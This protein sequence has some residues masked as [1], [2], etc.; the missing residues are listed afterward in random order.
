MTWIKIG[1]FVVPQYEWML[2]LQARAAM[3]AYR[4]HRQ[5]VLVTHAGDSQFA[6]VRGDG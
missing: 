4:L 6:C 2:A 1:V 5:R 3:F